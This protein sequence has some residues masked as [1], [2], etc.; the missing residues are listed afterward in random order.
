MTPMTKIA[1]ESGQSQSSGAPQFDRPRVRHREIAISAS[2]WP[3][4]TP[5]IVGITVQ[6]LLG[7]PS[8]LALPA[9]NFP[10]C[11]KETK[12]LHLDALRDASLGT[13]LDVP[14]EWGH[15]DKVMVH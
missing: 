15:K 6:K 8:L 14:L 5:A 4:C 2:G 11:G 1:L 10:V 7:R 3:P 12:P 13:V 9:R